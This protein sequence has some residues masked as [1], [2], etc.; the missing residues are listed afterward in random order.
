MA[1]RFSLLPAVW[2]PRAELV[3]VKVFDVETN[4]AVAVLKIGDLAGVALAATINPSF[5]VIMNGQTIDLA[6]VDTNLGLNVGHLADCINKA[7]K[8][9]PSVIQLEASLRSLVNE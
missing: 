6:Y 7:P 8:M 3:D 5:Q 4:V 2:R 1:G 9:P